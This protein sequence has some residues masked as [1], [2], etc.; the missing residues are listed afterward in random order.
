MLIIQIALGILLGFALITNFELILLGAIQLFAFA[1]KAA[2]YL[3]FPVIAGIAAATE[4]GIGEG[5]IAFFMVL[6]IQMY[7]YKDGTNRLTDIWVKIAES[8]IAKVFDLGRLSLLYVFFLSG[9]ALLGFAFVFAP[10]ILGQAFSG[11]ELEKQY[12]AWAVGICGL[13]GSPIGAYVMH[14]WIFKEMYSKEDSEGTSTNK[15]A[16]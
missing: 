4:K 15:Q 9:G 8:R 11:W 16:G 7:I 5:W 3:F 13:I 6:G 10:L 1:F 12:Q 2:A 14:K